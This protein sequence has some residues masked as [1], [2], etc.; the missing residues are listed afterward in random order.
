MKITKDMVVEMFYTLKN[1][2]GEV[3]DTNVG[4]D[5]MVYLHGH[6]QIVPG[7]E[8]ALEGKEKG[9]K[10]NTTVSPE[11]GYGNRSEEMVQVVDRQM[12]GGQDVQPGM[13]FHAES[14]GHPILITVAEVNGEEI[15][16]DGNHPLAGEN[17][18]FV[19]EVAGI[20][21]ASEEEIAHGH[22]HGPGGVQH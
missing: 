14:N 8:E 7:L 20:R 1:D 6:Q 16:I 11:K 18:H 4:H 3:V 10:I 5:P 13:Q 2:Q 15:K 12:F 22:V 9:C 19:V 17:L 21:E